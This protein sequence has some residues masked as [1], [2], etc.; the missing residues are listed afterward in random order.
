LVSKIEGPVAAL[1]AGAVGGGGEPAGAPDGP[2]RRAVF[3]PAG[4]PPAA[5]PGAGAAPAGVSGL[6]FVVGHPGATALPLFGAGGRGRGGGARGAG[7]PP[8]LPRPLRPV[9]PAVAA[10]R[11]RPRAADSARPFRA[12]PSSSRRTA[13][14]SASVSTRAS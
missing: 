8:R 7:R 3:S 5:A 10:A 2:G 14:S 6:A 11:P 9:Q 12:C 1:T 4:D 13:S